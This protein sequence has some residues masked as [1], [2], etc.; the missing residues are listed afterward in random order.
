MTTRLGW[1]PAN[2]EAWNE[3]NYKIY[4]RCLYDKTR[5]TLCKVYLENKKGISG[6]SHDNLSAIASSLRKKFS[7]FKKYTII[8]TLTMSDAETTLLSEKDIFVIE[9]LDLFS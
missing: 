8:P 7:A 9:L 1:F 4:A 2:K 5:A 3:G 6:Y